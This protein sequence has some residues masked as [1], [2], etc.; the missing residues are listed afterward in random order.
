MIKLDVDAVFSLHSI[1][2]KKTGGLFGVR[3]KN[4]LVSAVNAHFQTYSKQDILQ[5]IYKHS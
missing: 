2:I 3:D 4:L 1:A 5:W